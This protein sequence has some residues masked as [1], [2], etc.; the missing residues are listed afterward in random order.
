MYTMQISYFLKKNV[1]NKT[2]TVRVMAALNWESIKFSLYL[3]SQVSWRIH[4]KCWC[5]QFAAESQDKCIN[6]KHAAYAETMQNQKHTNPEKKC[7]RKK[8]LA[9]RASDK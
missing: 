5:W 9:S 8:L 4:A 7:N 1:L 3:E 2:E 6:S